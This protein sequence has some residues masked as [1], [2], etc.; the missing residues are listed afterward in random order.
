MWNILLGSMDA[1]DKTTAIDSWKERQYKTTSTVHS[2]HG[3][4]N[5][6]FAKCAVAAR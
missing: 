1:I 4:V 5:I 3:E 2:I 6:G